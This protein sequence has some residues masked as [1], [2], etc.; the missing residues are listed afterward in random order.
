MS[1]RLKTALVLLA[2]FLAFGIV[3]RMDYADALER[4]AFRHGPALARK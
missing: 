3:G 4:D 1:E 2:L